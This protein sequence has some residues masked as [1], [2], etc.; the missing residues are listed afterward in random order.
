MRALLSEIH[1]GMRYS[2]FRKP[3]PFSPL[4]CKD[5]TFLFIQQDYFYLEDYVKYKAHRLIT[6][7]E[8]NITALSEAAN[9]TASDAQYLI[10]FAE[11][12]LKNFKRNQ[13][14][15]DESNR[16]ITQ[17]AYGNLMRNAAEEQDWFNM[18]VISIPCIYVRSRFQ[19]T[20]RSLETRRC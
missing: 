10:T 18:H 19:R 7:P 1:S 6:L 9:E 15:L 8:G 2:N 16:T 3:L 13:S 17:L 20:I 12:Y 4:S 11:G 5:L 14:D